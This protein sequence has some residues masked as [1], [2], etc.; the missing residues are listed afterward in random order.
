MIIEETGL[1]IEY[2][3]NRIKILFSAKKILG[4]YSLSILFGYDSSQNLWCLGWVL[5]MDD[6]EKIYK[7]QKIIFFVKQQSNISAL[8]FP[9][10]KV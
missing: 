8:Q 10:Q 3:Y 1:N 2:R 6:K 4:Y 9:A 7:W 5:F